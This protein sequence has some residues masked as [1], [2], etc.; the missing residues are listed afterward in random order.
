M[1]LALRRPGEVAGVVSVDNAPVR[2][3][4]SRDFTKYIQAMR[5]I[6]DAKV[7]K[8]KEADDILQRYEDV[9]NVPSVLDIQKVWY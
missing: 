4:L 5:E 1:T 9:R 6:E 8:Q 3:A 2:A 7:T